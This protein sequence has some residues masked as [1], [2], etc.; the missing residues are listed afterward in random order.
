MSPAV[1]VV[2]NE[3][4]LPVT[5]ATSIASYGDAVTPMRARMLLDLGEAGR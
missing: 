3:E 2:H 1:G 5:S 4:L